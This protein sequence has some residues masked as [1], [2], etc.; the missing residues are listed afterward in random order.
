MLGLL[1]YELLRGRRTTASEA[2]TAEENPATIAS[3]NGTPTPSPAPSVLLEAE[4]SKGASRGTELGGIGEDQGRNEGE[5]C[6][7]E[8]DSRSVRQATNATEVV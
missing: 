5:E 7:K 3:G 4:A 1:P 2:A 8:G 6:C